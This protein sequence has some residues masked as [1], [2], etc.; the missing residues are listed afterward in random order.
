MKLAMPGNPMLQGDIDLDATIRIPPVEGTVKEKLI[1]DGTFQVSDG[2]FLKSQIRQR[3]DGLSRR[4]QGEP[5][6][7]KIEDVM[8]DLGGKMHVEDQMVSFP[9]LNFSVPGARVAL[10][11]SY[12]MDGGEI[13]FD[14]S[15]SLDAKASQMISGWKRILVKPFDPLFARNGAGTFLP[16]QIRGNSD[17]PDF[18]VPI[19]KAITGSTAQ[20]S[21]TP[22]S[23]KEN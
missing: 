3:L 18:S 22:N 12:N 13:Q 2:L 11:G 16:I 6:N 1:I 4:A 8:T 5:K 19:G 23:K 9:S 17:H 14:G 7:L 21:V 15:A 10:A 20:N